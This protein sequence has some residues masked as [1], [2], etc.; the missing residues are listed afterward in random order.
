MSF[1]L[2]LEEYKKLHPKRNITL[3]RIYPNTIRSERVVGQ[4]MFY[5]GE[6][7]KFYIPI[8]DVEYLTYAEALIEL[9]IHRLIV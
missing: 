6:G 8:L 4:S 7:K 5:D 9:E 2:I 3:S 1:N